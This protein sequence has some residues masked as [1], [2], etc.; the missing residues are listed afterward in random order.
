MRLNSIEARRLCETFRHLVVLDDPSVRQ[1]GCLDQCG[2][3]RY[4]TLVSP[5]CVTD[6]FPNVASL[7]LPDL[8]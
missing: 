5:L 2:V 6:P 8:R 3:H 1:T 7:Q 4:N